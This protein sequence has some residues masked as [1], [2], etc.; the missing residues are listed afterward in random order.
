MH[1][2]GMGTNTYHVHTCINQ[3][4]VYTVYVLTQMYVLYVYIV[5]TCTC[6][7]N[8]IYMYTVLDSSMR[9]K[10]AKV[11]VHYHRGVEG[12]PVHVHAHYIV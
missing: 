4:H 12:G 1:V 6:I 10:T 7:H 5:Y 9:R 8:Q 11:H 3:V 2:H